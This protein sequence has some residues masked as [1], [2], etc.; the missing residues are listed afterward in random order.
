MKELG[1]YRTKDDKSYACHFFPE[2]KMAEAVRLPDPHTGVG[3]PEFE[4]YAESEE[5]A[6]D[7]LAHAIGPGDF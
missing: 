6:R 4:I 7:K 2:T 3:R 1:I 5:D